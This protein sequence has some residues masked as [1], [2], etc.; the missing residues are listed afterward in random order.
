MRSTVLASLMAMGLAVAA[1]GAAF[2]AGDLE[3]TETNVATVKLS[4]TYGLTDGVDL[5]DGGKI[6]LLDKTTQKSL[7]CAGPYK[8]PIGDCPGDKKCGLIWRLLGRCGAT[9][10]QTPG[11]TRGIRP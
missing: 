9:E 5:P 6:T 8:G 4:Q 3:V 11:G 10:T 7:I 1:S 2:A